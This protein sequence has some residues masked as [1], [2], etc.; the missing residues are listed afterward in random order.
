[1][2]GDEAEGSPCW[3]DEKWKK[4]LRKY[5]GES[6]DVTITTIELVLLEFDVI[7]KLLDKSGSFKSGIS[8]SESVGCNVNV[9][10]EKVKDC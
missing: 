2:F 1:M 8:A 5:L 9:K 7:R 10:Y 4:D 3:K 6:F